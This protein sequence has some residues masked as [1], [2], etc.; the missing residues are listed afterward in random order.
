MEELKSKYNSCQYEPLT[1]TKSDP[2]QFV[3]K[4]NSVT[5]FISWIEHLE[6][7]FSRGSKYDSS[8]SG[9]ESF[10]LSRSL[11]HS[12]D[13]IREVK[14]DP[15]RQD[16][17]KSLIRT[18][19]RSTRFSE[20]GHELA[21]GE[22]L[23]GSDRYWLTEQDRRTVSRVINEPLFIDSCYNASVDSESMKNMALTLLEGIYRRRVVPRKMIV[24][25]L[26]NSIDG[27]QAQY[28]FIDVSF[29]DLNGIAKV[30]HPSM[31]RRLVF[32]LYEIYPRLSSGYGEV[33]TG[34]ETERGL[35]SLDHAYMR[36][37]RR[38]SEELFQ[39]EID[40]F[41]GMVTRK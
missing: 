16:N 14:F 41:L 27:R 31:F 23:A 28:I 10:T 7:N 3:F 18:I 34:M 40:K 21:I 17:L 20:E 2:E 37:W 29:S 6:K 11:K 33:R 9:S 39:P 5:H 38:G 35:I 8:E 24:S 25:F 13:V 4:F 32:R 19:K 30:L 26:N 1:P 36:V 12:Y 15:K 22:F